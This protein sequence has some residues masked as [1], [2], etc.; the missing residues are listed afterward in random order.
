MKIV[1]HGYFT[2]FEAARACGVFHTTV[3]NWVKKGRLKAHRTPGGHRRIAAEELLAF[4]RRFG[5]PVPPELGDGLKRVLVAEDEP[6]VQRVLRRALASL[7]GV[8][9]RVCQDGLEALIWIG[10]ENPDLLVLDLRMPHVDGLGVCRL[11]QSNAQTRPIKIVAMT[12]AELSADERRL[13]EKHAHAVFYK[14]FPLERL[15]D[16]V[17]RLLELDASAASHPSD[18]N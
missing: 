8:E 17:V 15:R 11:L 4:M 6:P 7:P 10:K 16:T 2:T 14:P 18:S 1:K 3:I 13:V 5:L 9:L 12:G